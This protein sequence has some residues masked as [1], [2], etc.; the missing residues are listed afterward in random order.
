[1]HQIRCWRFVGS[2]CLTALATRCKND[3]GIAESV[4]PRS[5]SDKAACAHRG[6]CPGLPGYGLLH[7]AARQN[8]GGVSAAGR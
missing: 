3:G 7:C 2:I 1:L 8:Q 5:W 6:A 4:K